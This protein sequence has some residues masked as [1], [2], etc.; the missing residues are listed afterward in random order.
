MSR[1]THRNGAAVT[2]EFPGCAA[3]FASH[4]ATTVIRDQAAAQGWARISGKEIRD[5]KGG[6]LS[7]KL[8]DL[9]PEHKPRPRTIERYTP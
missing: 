9:C 1:E 3:R 6:A 4:S 5:A 7:T 2:C 8:V